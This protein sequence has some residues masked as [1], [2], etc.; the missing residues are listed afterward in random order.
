MT[1]PTDRRGVAPELFRSE[2]AR[3][4]LDAEG[5]QADFLLT[6]LNAAFQYHLINLDPGAARLARSVVGSK[7]FYLDTNFLF[8]LLALHGPREAHGPALIADLASELSTDLR[9]ARATVDEFKSS[10]GYLGR[11]VRQSFLQRD[12]FRKIAADHG[13]TDL[14][15]MT[16]FYRQLQS[17][18]VRNVNEFESKCL[19]IE[20]ALEDWGIEVDEQCPWDQ[21]TCRELIDRSLELKN[22]TS[23]KKSEPSCE[24]DVLMEYYVRKIR[25]AH[26]GGLNDVDVW[27]LTYDRRLTR[28]FF[29]KPIEEDLPVTL[30]AEDWLQIVRYFSPRTEE[31][32]RAFLSLLSSTLLIDDQTVPF[33]HVVNALSRL[34]RYEG[35]SAKVVAGMI[36]ER[37]FVRRLNEPLDDREER[38]FVE[39]NVARVASQIEGKL[40]KALTRVKQVE[41][42]HDRVAGKLGETRA[43]IEEMKAEHDRALGDLGQAQTRVEQAESARDR[44]LR[45]RDESESTLK[46]LLEDREETVKEAVIS[47]TMEETRLRRQIAA[48]RFAL[49]VVS[50][51]A[52]VVAVVW[53]W[54]PVVVGGPLRWRLFLCLCAGALQASATGFLW[55][56]R[57]P[58]AIA[59]VVV[60]VVTL[61]QFLLGN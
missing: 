57:K 5:L 42:D 43:R 28:F 37:E 31:Y 16:E 60:L 24:H 46:G 29:R 7:I 54:S 39:L 55:G 8:R 17:G 56:H 36:V 33:P 4:V 10:V 51:L 20:R 13:S 53:L 18:L 52:L 45:E 12:D 2:V 59:G 22:W 25:K 9:V 38:Q 23:G 19:Q 14:G 27:F 58:G 21:D 34:E 44:T 15:F 30:L 48:L 61:L 35:L 11:E 41:S 49:T 1:F 6:T 47:K 26:R 50:A 3:F 40:D 32:D